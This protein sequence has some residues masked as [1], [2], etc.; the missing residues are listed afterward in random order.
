ME[1]WFG[2]RWLGTGYVNNYRSKIV[3]GRCFYF[4]FFM[5]SRLSSMNDA[6]NS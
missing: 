2:C 1:P 3:F 5:K 4:V 6:P